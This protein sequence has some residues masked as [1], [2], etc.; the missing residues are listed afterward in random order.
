MQT[1]QYHI[2]ID[3]SKVQELYALLTNLR[4]VQRVEVLPTATNGTVE[5]PA[6]YYTPNQLAYSVEEIRAI[7][8]RGLPKTSTNI[9]RQTSK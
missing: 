8:D 6:P 4:Y 5:E 2:T 1:F 3:E 7:A 9:S